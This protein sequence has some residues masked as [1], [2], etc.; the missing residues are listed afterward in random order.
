MTHQNSVMI[1]WAGRTVTPKQFKAAID[2]LG[3]SQ[4]RA[5]KLCGFHPRSAHLPRRM[6]MKLL[7]TGVAALLRSAYADF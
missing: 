7:L 5:A 2:A 1:R 4:G 6:R 3:L